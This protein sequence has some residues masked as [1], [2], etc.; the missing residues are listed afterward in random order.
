MVKIPVT[1]VKP[2]DV[3]EFPSSMLHEDLAGLVTNARVHAVEPTQDGRTYLVWADGSRTWWYN[4]ET[5]KVNR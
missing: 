1:E 4:S 2:G 5:V 3:V